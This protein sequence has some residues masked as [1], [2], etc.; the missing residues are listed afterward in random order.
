[1]A[2]ASAAD[3]GWVRPAVRL[4]AAAILPLLVPLVITGL[5]WALPGD[6]AEIVCPRELCAG[7]DELARRWNLDQGAW[8]FYVTWLGGAL[9]GDWGRS[10]RVLQGVPVRELLAEAVPNT[11]ALL[12]AGA[13]PLLAAAAAGAS[14]RVPARVEGVAA[15]SG[16]VPAV[17]FAL[18]CA[19][20][21]DLRFG[22]E[23]FT[24]EAV[25][26]RLLLGAGVLVLADGAAASA[27]SGARQLFARERGER[28]VQTAR[29]RG[30]GALSNMLPNLA[31]ALAGQLRARLVQLLSATVVVEV[32]LRIDGVGDLLWAGTLSQDFGVVLAAAGVYA[33]L[34]AALLALQAGV[35]LGVVAAVRRA[36][37]LGHA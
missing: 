1:M 22:A 28:Y 15:A 6:P 36:P 33:A 31:P 20:V 8:H 2:G 29:L 27:L 7:T 23:A 26:L 19:A 37:V 11:L 13:L 17:V 30:E 3:A 10:W 4:A 34:S 24:P 14:G 12:G 9:G 18:L 25:R 16:F 35:E 32:V 5:V 21:V